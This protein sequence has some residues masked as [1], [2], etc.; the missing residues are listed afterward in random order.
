[1]TTAGAWPGLGFDPA[2]GEQAGVEGLARRLS[3]VARRLHETHGS[4][5]ELSRQGRWS[6]DAATAFAGSLE[7]LPRYLLDA[8]ES[9]RRA[10]D[11]LGQWHAA[12]G[13]LQSRARELES[14]AVA[15]RMQLVSAENAERHARAH[16]DFALI[17]RQFSAQE[18]PTAQA[19]IDAAQAG[20]DRAA[21]TV[22]GL[23]GSLEDL[24]RSAGALR[25]EHEDAARGAAEGV[26][27]A[28][29]GLAP[30]EPGWFEQAAGWVGDNLAEIGDVAGVISGI[31]SAAALIPI[32]TPIAGP[33]ALVAGGVALLAHGADLVVN[34]KWN[35]PGAVLDVL[36]D[37]VGV[38]PGGR[39]V[40]GAAGDLV[41]ASLNS[42]PGIGHAL[43]AGW[44]G[45]TMA[46]PRAI[47]DVGSAGGIATRVGDRLAPLVGTHLP[48]L[49]GSVDATSV[50][51]V[52]QGVM[53]VAP[54][55]PTMNQLLSGEDNTAQK[56]IASGGS[57]LAG[58]VDEGL[59]FRRLAA[60]A[61]GAAS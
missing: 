24:L 23:R 47:D 11:V 43:A 10:G 14:Q 55:V 36:A 3:T 49:A 44:E 17:G 58:V 30:P 19:R 5:T 27:R 45:V 15:A 60:A 48:G 9:L 31:A 29:D 7:V 4:L 52:A 8:H 59:E 25:S 33:I 50:A 21:A 46:V 42:T 20:V 38:I 57:I 16:P 34:D 18:L 1:M 39:I 28:D 22:A 2:P 37:A 12:L 54:Q 61:A 40:L 32:L 6:G 51:K 56:N 13:R 35:E 53:D 41:W 26:R